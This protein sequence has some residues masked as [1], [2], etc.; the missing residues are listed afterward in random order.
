M[1]AD[2]LNLRD[3]RR[4]AA[5]GWQPEPDGG[6]IY[7]CFS[8]ASIGAVAA[9]IDAWDAAWREAPQSFSG[10]EIVPTLSP[11]QALE[12]LVAH[13]DADWQHD[14]DGFAGMVG[15]DIVTSTIRAK[16]GNVMFYA[17][18]AD[19]V[20]AMLDRLVPEKEAL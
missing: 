2:V 17:T 20:A 15:D 9:M 12:W 14:E 10:V 18:A 11:L 1:P 19:L 3:C 8:G 13:K 5:L 4:M 6:V 16:P 7:R